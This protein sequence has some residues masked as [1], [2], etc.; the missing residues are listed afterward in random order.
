VTAV[1]NPSHT[2]AEP[3]FSMFGSLRIRNY[4]L[5]AIGQGISVAGNWMQNIA[6][7]WLT[8]ELTHSGTM[9]GIV[10][11]ARYAPVLLFGS[12]G[13]VIADRS[14]NRRLLTVTQ[15]AMALVSF[16]LAFLSWRGLA[17]LPV[18]LAA[19]VS[20]GMV[21]VFDGPS[22]QSLISQLVDRKHLINAIALNS[23]MMNTAKIVGPGLGGVLVAA[24][25][26]TPCFFINALSFVAVII[27][28]LVMRPSEFS[29]AER[30]VRAKGQIMAGLRYVADTPSLRYPLLMVIVTGIL[31]W[32]FPVTLPLLT[33]TG[34][35][36]GAT[37]YGT[38]MT[39]MGVGAVCG[40][41]L[42]ARRRRLTV[43]SLAV[44]AVL[45]G[46]VITAASLAP[47]L[48]LT[49]GLLV[50]V[51]SCSITFNS[52]AKT[53]LQL[54]SQPSMRGRV[55]SLWSIAWQGST[56][57]GA[58]IVGVIGATVGARYALLVGGI[59]ALAVGAYILPIG[60]RSS[61]NLSDSGEAGQAV[62]V[63]LPDE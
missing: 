26:V 37:A 11:G 17:T 56:V 40:G 52:M 57:I 61:A 60:R 24:V 10:T 44:S 38:A 36:A 30:A 42:A 25:G 16:L 1:A 12:W 43:R 13:G 2:A 18:L 9:L 23:V 51:G 50:I 46:V 62:A 59:A 20:L 41:L 3:G 54:E 58:P 34:F 33:T 22:R 15:T 39:C 28:L 8:L 55:M 35:H 4:R 14:D 27:S 53:L 29:P 45:W 32:E 6:V 31:T 47:T 63:T 19:V 21:N 5:Y 49:F 7:G 48:V